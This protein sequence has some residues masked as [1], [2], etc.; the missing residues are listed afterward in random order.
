MAPNYHAQ[1]LPHTRYPYISEIKLGW[2]AAVLL[3]ALI[4]A[5]LAARESIKS[6]RKKDEVDLTEEPKVL[7]EADTTRK[8]GKKNKS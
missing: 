8:K 4:L 6:S 7:D 1:S 3:A 2:T 5:I